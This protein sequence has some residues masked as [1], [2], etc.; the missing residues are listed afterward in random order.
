MPPAAR[1]LLTR[2]YGRVASA[3][4]N[5]VTATIPRA[6]VGETVRIDA[7]DGLRV[8]ATVTRIENGRVTLAAHETLAGVAIGDVVVSDAFA[9][10]VPLGM[11]LLGRA[12]APSGLPLD[13]LG[14][15]AGRATPILEPPISSAERTPIDR[16][17]WTGIRGIDAFATIGRGARIGFFGGPGTGKSMLVE[18]LVR[19]ASADA[20][21]VGLIGERGREAAAWIQRIAPHAT[22]VC[23]P[24]DRP[25]A[26]R[27]RAAHV[28]MAQGSRLRAR[29]LNVLVVLDSLARF[30]AAAREIAAQSGE[31]VGRGGYPP[32]VFAELT[33][34]L[35]RGG[36]VNGGSLTLI[37]T[38]LSDGADE[39]EPLTD[40][41]RA[42]LDGHIV[43]C[44]KRARTGLFPAL[45]V[46]ASLS[47]TMDTVA[48]PRHRD[49]ARSLRRALARLETTRELRELG[50]G[51]ADP[52][53]DRAVAL[54]EHIEAFV[55]HGTRTFGPNE[56]LAELSALA[57][58]LGSGTG[59]GAE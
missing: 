40:A 11:R 56:T 59:A 25:P 30:A 31:S 50:F 45:D 47:R 8:A 15:V 52:E 38:V 58:Q 37:A 51:Q 57:A 53:L 36:N 17:F 10:S 21:V 16:P 4:A 29:G 28:A 14:P 12:I 7:R 3:F 41:A 6:R 33:R 20:V 55:H 35:E 9:A 44:P 26:E 5:S 22:I 46:V 2:R 32:S 13:A 48:R 54:Q 49:A 19:G 23:A 39:R 42:A 34:L 27:M 43:L 24:S 18:M 1:E